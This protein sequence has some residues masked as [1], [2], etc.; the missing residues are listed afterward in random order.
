MDFKL[1]V[2]RLLAIFRVHLSNFFL[3]GILLLCVLLWVICFLFG[4]VWVLGFFVLFCDKY[5]Y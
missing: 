4:V 3:C 5:L 2:G 1:Q